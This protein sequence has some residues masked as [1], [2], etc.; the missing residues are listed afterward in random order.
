M[1]NIGTGYRYWLNFQWLG[2]LQVLDF[3]FF[4]LLDLGRLHAFSTL[5]AAKIFD[6]SK[7]SIHSIHYLNDIQSKREHCVLVA[8]HQ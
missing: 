1:P 4:Q 8:G 6:I 3:Q 2:H 7:A 5:G